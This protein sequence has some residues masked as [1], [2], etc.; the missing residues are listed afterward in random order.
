MGKKE[1]KKRRR[2][3]VAIRNDDAIYG[4]ENTESVLEPAL[5]PFD[6]LIRSR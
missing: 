2:E 1:K 4:L 5:T 6:R 3:R